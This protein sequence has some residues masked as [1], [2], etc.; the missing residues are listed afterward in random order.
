MI[1]CYDE[2]VHF[3][4]PVFTNLRG[5]QAKAMWHMMVV[6]GQDLKV[7]YGDITAGADNGRA[8]WEAAYTF[9]TGRQVHN[10][11]EAAFVFR[12]G[13]IIEHHDS[14]DLW[15][16]TRMALGVSGQLFGWTPYVQN[17]VRKTAMTGLDKFIAK[18]PEYQ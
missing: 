13:L 1:T 11:I 14:F 16:W 3:S 10:V 8:H 15:R 4:D 6:R 2:Q 5:P 7:T 12:D 9:S 17:K 18:H